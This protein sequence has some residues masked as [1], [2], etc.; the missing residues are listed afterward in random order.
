MIN[1]MFAGNYKVFDGMVLASLSIVKHTKEQVNVYILTM[2]KTD[3]DPRYVAINNEQI[4]YLQKIYSAANP[5]N[6]VFKVDVIDLYNK[7]LDNTKNSQ[8]TYT[9]YTLLRLL[10]DKIDILPD[11]ILY[12]DTD[13]MA[14]DDI[15]LL[16]NTDITDYEVAMVKDYYGKVFI[17]RKYCNA[18]VV[19]MN[20]AKIKET[21]MLEKALDQCINNKYVLADQTS[22]HKAIKYKLILPSRFNEQH[23]MHKDTVIRH[24]SMSLKFFPYFRKQNI[25]PWHIDKVHSVLKCHEFDD[26]LEDYLSRKKE[27]DAL[28]KLPNIEAKEEV[29]QENSAGEKKAV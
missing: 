5:K 12:L 25:K 18:G 8:T 1:I 7:Y 11:K 17:N 13:V 6:Q 21:K 2:D 24:F 15:G 26:I 23:K 10:A 4:D 3:L 19:L 22:L 16:Y 14:Y 20:L 28:I 29:P 27:M 9:P